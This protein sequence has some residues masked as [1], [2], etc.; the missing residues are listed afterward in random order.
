MSDL[1]GRRDVL[2]R[3]P[4]LLA[5]AAGAL[6]CI[7]FGAALAHGAHFTYPVAAAAVDHRPVSREVVPEPARL[8][9]ATP[10]PAPPIPAPV[11]APVV[12]SAAAAAPARVTV[13][14]TPA[15]L[16]PGWSCAAAIAYL[17][18]HAAPGFTFICPGDAFGH[19]AMTCDNQSGV[20]PGQKLIVI[21]IPCPAAYENEAWNSRVLERLAS[22]PIDPYGNCRRSAP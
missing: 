6:L 12:P 8:T 22:G 9:A 21:A 20:C 11:P 17:D 10:I 4:G 14:I 5:A 7:G 2:A 13:Q 3:L 19:Q 16:P 15:A 1:V 18:A